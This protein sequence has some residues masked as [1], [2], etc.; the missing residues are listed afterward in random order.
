[1]ELTWLGR[2]CFQLITAN[3]THILFDPYLEAY[4]QKYQTAYPLPDMIC[5]SHGHLDHFGEVPGLIAKDSPALV[6]AVPALCRVLRQLLPDTQ[7]RLFPVPWDDRVEVEGVL[8]SAFRS[9]PMQT[10][11]Y[12]MFQEFGADKVLKFLVAFR[13]AAEEILYLPLTSFG[14]EADRKRILHFVFE[15]EGDG[16]PVDVAAIGRQFAPDVALVGVQAGDEARSAAYAAQLGAPVVIPHHYTAGAAF[17][18]CE[19]QS[20]PLQS[21]RTHAA[22]PA[23]DLPFFVQELKRLAPWSMILAPELMESIQI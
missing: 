14:V 11:L 5:V 20:C 9:P 13:Q 7:H 3:K 18:T 23:A 6:I 4:R 2:S 10:S 16:D 22:L 1:M 12:E 8:F 15:G 17:A 21:C 19:V